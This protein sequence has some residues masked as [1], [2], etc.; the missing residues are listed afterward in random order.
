MEHFDVLPVLMKQPLIQ[1][2]QE[3]KVK[4]EFAC[5]CLHA[6]RTTLNLGRSTEEH[7]NIELIAIHLAVSSFVLSSL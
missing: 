2:R 1:D 3:L 5:C 6:N 4:K 7:Y